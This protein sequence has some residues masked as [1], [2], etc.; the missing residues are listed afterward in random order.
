MVSVMTVVNV[1]TAK[2]NPS[3]KIITYAQ[4]GVFLGGGGGLKTLS[5][6]LVTGSLLLEMRIVDV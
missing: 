1:T 4:T 5:A 3:F 2:K 6:L